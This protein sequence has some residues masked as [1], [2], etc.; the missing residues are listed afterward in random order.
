[1]RRELKWQPPSTPFSFSLLLAMLL[2]Q[3][4]HTPRWV[5]GWSRVSWKETSAWKNTRPW[6]TWCN[7]PCSR[8]ENV[9]KAWQ[10]SD[11][12]SLRHHHSWSHYLCL[13]WLLLLDFAHNGRRRFLNFTEIFGS[14]NSLH[15]TFSRTATVWRDPDLV[16]MS[17]SSQSKLNATTGLL[18]DLWKSFKMCFYGHCSVTRS[19]CICFYAHY[20]VTSLLVCAYFIW[21]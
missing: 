10:C 3:S 8:W 17:D 15:I 20:N 18:G 9:N 4:W 21:P 14:S 12:L 2:A 5:T 6:E 1:M 7:T 19:F 13:P 11:T 16:W